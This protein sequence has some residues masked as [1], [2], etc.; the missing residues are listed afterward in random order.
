MGWVLRNGVYVPAIESAYSPGA[1]MLYTYYTPTDTDWS[2]MVDAMRVRAKQLSDEMVMSRVAEPR[3]APAAPQA[4][5]PPDVPSGS[6]KTTVSTTAPT[7]AASGGGLTDKPWFWPAVV[8][9]GAVG[10]MYLRDRKRL[11]R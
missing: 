7:S 5:A 9:V 10:F 3:I 4:P 8:V 1:G 2:R 11:G 6:G